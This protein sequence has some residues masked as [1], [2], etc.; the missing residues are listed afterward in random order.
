MRVGYAVFKRR[1][2]LHTF[3]GTFCDRN[4]DDGHDIACIGN[5][6]HH[7]V[8][9]PV[10]HVEHV[11]IEYVFRLHQNRDDVFIAERLF[12]A[13]GCEFDFLFVAEPIFLQI[14]SDEF[15]QTRKPDC[16]DDEHRDQKKPSKFYLDFSEFSKRFVYFQYFHSYS[17]TPVV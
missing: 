1:D 8:S 14:F 12:K 3:I 15:S 11:G 17:V 13:V 10:D 7:F 16:G 2:D 5:R 4:F 9:E 6:F